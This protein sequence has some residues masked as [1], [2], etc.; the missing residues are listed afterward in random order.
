MAAT[1]PPIR[2]MG[3]KLTALPALPGAVVVAAGELLVVLAAAVDCV[4]EA[5]VEELDSFLVEE[6][7]EE[8]PEVEA[9]EAAVELEAPV[10]EAAVLEAA[11]MEE[12]VPVYWNCLE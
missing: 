1:A 9:E 11:E 8:A 2:A 3:E 12:P 10:V 6:E 4:L 7:E 5:E